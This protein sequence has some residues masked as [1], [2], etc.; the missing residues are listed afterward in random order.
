MSPD[1]RRM[2]DQLPDSSLVLD[3]GGWADP[4]PRADWVIDIGSYDTRRWYEH[5]LGR[6]ARDA[7]ERFTRETWVQMDICCAAPWPFEDEMFDFVL[8]TQTLEDVR[9]PVRVCAEMTRVGKAGYIE[10]PSAVCELTRGIESPFW[11]GWKHHRWLVREKDGGLAFL[12][13]PHHIHSPLWPSIRSPR[14]LL[15]EAARPLEFR[16]TNSFSTHEEILVDQED[17]DRVLGEIVTA[18]SLPDLLGAVRRN[19]AKQVWSGY[20]V[21]RRGAGRLLGVRPWTGGA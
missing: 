3:V 6:P 13:K 9:D 5:A 15:P 7:A 1:V 17:L 14:R 21:V 12:A 20:R 8:C 10:T 11:C 16:W 19:A 18:S 4:D 2:L